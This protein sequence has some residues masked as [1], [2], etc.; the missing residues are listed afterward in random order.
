[1]RT[2]LGAARRVAA[3]VFLLLLP[4]A[5]Q[6]GTV[7]V[8]FDFTGSSVAILGG[9]IDVPPDGS[10]SAGSGLLEVE[11][12][13]SA[14]PSGG[15]AR[16]SNLSLAGTLDK[17]GLGVN[18][19]GAIAA[20]QPGTANGNLTAGLGSLSFNPFLM[21]FTGFANCSNTGPGSGCTVLGLPTTFTGPKTFTLTSLG[22][23]S[24]AS[25]GNAGL[26]G[27]FTF[28]RGGF[29]AVLNL[30]GNEVSRTFVP[31]P[32]TFGLLALGLAGVAAL[33]RHRS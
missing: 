8:E 7:T 33:R 23:S 2:S 31:E 13:G 1:M 6:A 15:P 19:T 14:T 30:V 10:I 4:L 11:A 16:L 29:T 28:T 25:V 27:T 21:N 24:L 32:N 5:S 18:I 3:T 12:A 26:N 17:N 9:F 22:V 20:T